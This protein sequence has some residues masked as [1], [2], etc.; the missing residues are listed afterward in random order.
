ME[1]NLVLRLVD[2]LGLRLDLAKPGEFG[3][4]FK[5]RSVD[6]DSILDEYRDR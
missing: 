1:F 5:G 6:L 4:V 2:H 3:D